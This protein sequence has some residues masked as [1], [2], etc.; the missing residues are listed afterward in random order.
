MKTYPMVLEKIQARQLLR[1]SESTLILLDLVPRSLTVR[2][3]KP[4]Y[5]MIYRPVVAASQP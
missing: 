4:G 5:M 1:S 2:T 3:Y